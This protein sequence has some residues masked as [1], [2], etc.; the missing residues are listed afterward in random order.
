MIA[1]H[2]T[3]NIGKTLGGGGGVVFT[4]NSEIFAILFFVTSK[5]E[6]K[7]LVKPKTASSTCST[8]HLSRLDISL[9]CNEELFQHIELWCDE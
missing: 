5:L 7:G 1:C 8:L 3:S 6:L 2:C 4:V 9:Q